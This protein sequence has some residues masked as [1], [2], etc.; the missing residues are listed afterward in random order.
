VRHRDYIL[1]AGCLLRYSQNNQLIPYPRLTTGDFQNPQKLIFAYFVTEMDANNETTILVTGGSGFVSLHCIAQAVAAGYKVRTTVRSESKKESVLKGLKN[2]QPPVDA[3]KVEF[4]IADLLKDDGWAEAVQ[5]VSLVLHVASPFP[6]VQPRDENELIR[7]AMDGTLRV[8]KAAKASGTVKR[9]VVTSSCA[10]ILYGHP[11][12]K[13]KIYTE[14]DWSDPNGQGITPYQKSKT[15]AERAAWDYIEREGGGLELS[16]VNP[17]G[18]FGPALLLPC[19]ST[20]VGIIQRM[21]EGKL[22]AAPDIYFNLID[23]RDVA[24]L[25]LLAATK[26]E[27][28]G[29]RYSCLAGT[30]KPVAFIEIAGFLKAGLGSKASKVPTRTM[31][32]VLV[33]LVS[34]VVPQLRSLLPELGKQK[35]QSN[36][37]AKSL[38]W[39]P[40]STEESIVSCGQALIDAGICK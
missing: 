27:A 19:E 22:P 18:I 5:S 26:P 23:V 13:G 37:K 24:S 6:G 7:P 8:L 15:L 17:V 40:R 20:T 28:N 2:A 31:P 4:V 25:H 35:E 3:S 12:E 34:Y 39:N 29:Q 9:V 32:N 1:Q 38:G 33:K 16:V 36:E 21:M 14:A 10:A 11:Y 30:G